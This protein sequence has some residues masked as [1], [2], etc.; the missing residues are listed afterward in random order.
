MVGCTIFVA[1]L[2]VFLQET[3][4]DPNLGMAIKM[5]PTA[6]LA[7]ALLATPG[8]WGSNNYSVAYI[9]NKNA[10]EQEKRR[11]ASNEKMRWSRPCRPR[12]K[13]K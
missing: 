11:A 2:W 3:T 9:E 6:F 1:L 13:R 12:K 4:R 7:L 8:I 5:I 10:C